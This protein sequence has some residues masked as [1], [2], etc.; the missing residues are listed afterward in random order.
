MTAARAIEHARYTKGGAG[1]EFPAH[2]NPLD[3]VNEAGEVLCS[4][5]NWEW[6]R[7]ATTTLDLK[8]GQAYAKLP[9]DFKRMVWADATNG[10]ISRVDLVSPAAFLEL[11]TS[12]STT[13]TY[14]YSAVVTYSRPRNGGPVTPRLD[15]WPTPG[16]DESGALTIAYEAGWR[17][18]DE[19]SQALTLPPWLLS[20]YLEVLQRVTRGRLEEDSGSL[21]ERMQGFEQSSLF[22]AAIR[23]DATAQRERG[24]MARTHV[25]TARSINAAWPYNYTTI[26]GPS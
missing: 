23:R 8:N 10:L 17:F 26:D 24:P 14:E 3:L 1:W 11:T 15:I 2:I 12:T 5:H 16:A 21:A 25:S 19:A 4:M 7:S 20:C 13:S 6:Q 9:T 18:V 22:L